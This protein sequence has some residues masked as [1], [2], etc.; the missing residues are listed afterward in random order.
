MFVREL[1]IPY[2]NSPNSKH[3]KKSVLRTCT[4]KIIYGVSKRKKMNNRRIREIEERCNK[5]TEGPWISFVEDRDF[6]CG[7]SFIQT[8]G[9]DIEL[10]GATVDDQDFIAN[11]RQDIPWLI[12]EIRRLKK[13]LNDLGYNDST[14]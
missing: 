4:D 13:I 12:D 11:A 10:I 14:L 3:Y 8:S 6:T 7:S 9:N 5:V 2:K 1:K